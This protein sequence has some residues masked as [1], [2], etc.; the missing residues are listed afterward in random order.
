M[1]NELTALKRE[2]NELPDFL[3]QEMGKLENRTKL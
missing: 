2:R 3:Y 1:S